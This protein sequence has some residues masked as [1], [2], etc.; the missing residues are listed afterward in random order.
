MY[1]GIKVGNYFSILNNCLKKDLQK[2]GR[3]KRVVVSLRRFQRKV[4]IFVKIEVGLVLKLVFILRGCLK[5]GF[6]VLKI[7]FKIICKKFGGR[8]CGCIFAPP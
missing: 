3:M 8:N 5:V 6:D 2:L 7:N 4:V 1:F